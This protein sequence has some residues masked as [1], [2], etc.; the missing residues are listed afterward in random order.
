MRKG[1]GCGVYT[2]KIPSKLPVHIFLSGG[3]LLSTF[4]TQTEPVWNSSE[5]PTLV[6][7]HSYN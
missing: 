5:L 6:A 7:H 3:W 4:A 2:R 1:R